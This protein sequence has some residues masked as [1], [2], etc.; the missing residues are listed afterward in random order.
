MALECLP[1]SALAQRQEVWL[2]LVGQVLESAAAAILQEEAQA[3]DALHLKGSEAP[4]AAAP[5]ASVHVPGAAPAA[6]DCG[7][8]LEEN[9]HSGLD[10]QQGPQG[11]D[12]SVSVEAW[13]PV[14]YGLLLL[15]KILAQR[16]FGMGHPPGEGSPQ[17]QVSGTSLLPGSLGPLRVPCN[18]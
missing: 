10:L 1:P 15:E 14:Y 7:P 6:R 8:R 12:S 4:V 17:A 2:E 11:V 9:S 16:G 13:E 5:L 3:L 18:P